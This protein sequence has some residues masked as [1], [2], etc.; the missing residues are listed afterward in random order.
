[1]KAFPI[2]SRLA[3]LL[4]FLSALPALGQFT[5]SDDAYTSTTNPSVNF[6]A[7]QLLDVQS[8]SQTSYIRFDLSA[9]PAGYTGANIS[10]ATLKLYVNNVTTA[11][12]FNVDLVNGTWTEGAIT[13]NLGPALGSSVAAGV[14]LTMASRGDYVIVDVTS[15]V[16]GWLNGTEPNYGL[17]LVANSPLNA[18][19]D[20]KENTNQSHSPELDIVFTSSLITSVTT[21]SGSGLTGGGTSGN[22]NLSLTNSCAANQVLQWS[23]SAW[24]CTTLSGSGSGT[25]SSVGLAAPASDFV[26]TGS[27]VT[28][29]GTLGLNWIVPPDVNATPNSIVRRDL[30]GA[31]TA[32]GINAGTVNS[33]NGYFGFALGS[34]QFPGYGVH[35]TGNGS[36]N[37]SYG[38]WAE[39]QAVDGVTGV[40]HGYGSGVVAVNDYAGDGILAGAPG[41][42]ATG[43]YAG[44]FNGDV[45]VNGTLH[46]SAGTFKIDHPLDPANKY[47][48]HS[49]VESPDM[50]NIYN[51]NA[52]LDD[53]GEAVVQLPEWFET[54]N[55]D[56]RYSLT[57]IGAPAMLY[58]AEEVSGN[59]F[60]IAG[61]RPG[62]KVSW[63]IT[64]IRHDA[65]ANA[66]R[67][68]VEQDKPE[69]E[70]GF[71]LHPEL[72][73]AS[74]QQGVLW[75]RR[76]DTM[77]HLHE[78]KV[79]SAQARAAQ[80]QEPKP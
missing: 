35:V 33:S 49:F 53:R 64:G 69:K 10:K 29:S 45:D 75:A 68:P 56:F 3:A 61:G 11:G 63:Q 30:L 13:A 47:L 9:L 74:E 20:S 73:G 72:F 26:V 51:G 27:P 36:G 52:V 8:A 57:P 54:L 38:V 80:P 50:M 12:S 5:P 24:S 23:G 67:T 70:R 15:A 40:S 66:H 37:Y 58:V 46:K 65:Y 22:L 60:K 21:S 18:A 6:G 78:I 77:R 28:G 71:Y 19:F 44:W 4:V 59:R 41:S 25:V 32:S 34:T 48:Y 43:T 2:L 31:V 62:G 55:R 79:K 16:V 39:S 1:M 7:R 76:P 42:S 14:P 17:A